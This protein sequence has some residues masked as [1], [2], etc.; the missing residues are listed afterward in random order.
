MA[1]DSIQCNIIIPIVEFSRLG[2]CTYLS[3]REFLQL[4]LVGCA[5]EQGAAFV[6]DLLV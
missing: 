1:C 3:D 4:L 5:P 2:T 6:F